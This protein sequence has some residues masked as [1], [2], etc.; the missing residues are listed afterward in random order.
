MCR[1]DKRYKQ[2]GMY[3]GPARIVEKTHPNKEATTKAITIYTQAK[4][5]LTSRIPVSSLF[6]APCV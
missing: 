4:S 6:A 2:K 5:C 3:D 1:L